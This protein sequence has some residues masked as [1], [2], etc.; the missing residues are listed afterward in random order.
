LTFSPDDKTILAGI[1]SDLQLFDVATKKEVFD[2]P[3][4]R[5]PVEYLS[6]SADG[7][8][9]HSGSASVNLHPREVTT[10]DATTFKQTQSASTRDTFSPA[11]GFPTLNQAF[12]VGKDGDDRFCL[13]DLPGGKLRGRFHVPA[14]EKTPGNP[15]FFSPDGKFLVLPGGRDEK[16]MASTRLFGVPSSKLL[17][18]LPPP[19]PA[20]GP[21]PMPWIAFSA[22]GRRVA[23]FSSDQKFHVFDTASGK[24]L[25]ELGKLSPQAEAELQAGFIRGTLGSLALSSDGNLLASWKSDDQLVRIWD[26]NTGKEKMRFPYDFQQRNRVVL[27][28]SPDNKTLA[29]GDTKIEIWEIASSKLRREFDGHQWGIRSLA[30]SP[31]GR[32]LASGSIDTTV[33]VWDVWVR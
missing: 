8:Y 30:F 32:L 22:D 29:V 31:D 33:L 5:G 14:N 9:L 15:G 19:G 2:W 4:H 6:F 18:Q 21:E 12:Y 7:K 10:W 24:L 17:C 27:A 13:F 23:V 11:I 16:G 28:W 3:G 1:G 26:V 25:H 20:F